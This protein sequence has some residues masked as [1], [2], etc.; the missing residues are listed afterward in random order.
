[1]F[2]M[3]ADLS[4]DNWDTKRLKE[5]NKTFEKIPKNEHQLVFT[6][7][8]RRGKVVTLVGRFF[9]SDKEKKVILK[10]LKTKL[11]CGGSIKGEWIELQGDIKPKV[12][13]ILKPLDW[14]F[15]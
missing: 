2:T 13:D 3:G 9:I 5:P 6:L 4:G 14:K 7:E 1:M 15:K 10:L 12:I 8:K 11:G